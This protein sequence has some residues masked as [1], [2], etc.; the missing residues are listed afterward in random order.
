MDRLRLLFEQ[1]NQLID[2]LL[3]LLEPIFQFP[4]NEGGLHTLFKDFQ[5]PPE[6]V[7]L[8]FPIPLFFF[9]DGHDFFPRFGE[10][11]VNCRLIKPV[12]RSAD[13]REGSLSGGNDSG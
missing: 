12:A 6:L 13:I 3:R 5:R 10:G 7:L 1:R 8:S 11:D 4:V 2:C 9:F